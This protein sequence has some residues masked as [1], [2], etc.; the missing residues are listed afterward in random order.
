APLFAPDRRVILVDSLQ[1]GRSDKPAITGPMWDFHASYLAQLFGALDIERP[2]VVCNS[3][4][5]TQAMCL[6]AHQPDAV[7]MLVITGAMPV[8]YGPLAPLPDGSRRGRN[9]RSVYYGDEGPTREKMRDLMARLEW[10]DAEAIP[11]DT[12]DVRYTQSLQTDEID[13]G[14][15]PTNRGEWQD[16]TDRLP[17]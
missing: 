11:D 13:C 16:L 8:F 9:A 10:F 4:G 1:Y 3:W 14:Q 15:S 12:L 7:R 17:L 5:G 6:A 2:D